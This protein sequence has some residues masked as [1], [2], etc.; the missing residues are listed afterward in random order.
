MKYIHTYLHTSSSKLCFYSFLCENI[1]PS[2]PDVYARYIFPPFNRCCFSFIKYM[3]N[4]GE[5]LND[6]SDTG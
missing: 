1:I 5:L 4:H 3:A 6:V 2:I